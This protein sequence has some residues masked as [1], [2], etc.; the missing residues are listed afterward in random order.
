[1]RKGLGDFYLTNGGRA[2]AGEFVRFTPDLAAG[3]Y[4]VS[5]SPECPFR[6]DSQLNVRVRH[7]AGD[8]VVRVKPAASRVIGAFDFAEG[9]DGFVELLGEGSAG[10]VVADAVTFRRLAASG[11]RANPKPPAE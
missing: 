2:T 8:T 1:M 11:P 4:E 6:R 9:A 5:F 3:R 10:L 7:R